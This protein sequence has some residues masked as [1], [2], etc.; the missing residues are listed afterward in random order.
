MSYKKIWTGQ[1]SLT[2]LDG[3]SLDLASSLLP[4]RSRIKP[5]IQIHLHLHAR[6][7]KKYADKPN[8][9]IVRKNTF[10]LNARLGLLESLK[11][12]VQ[13]FRWNPR[14]PGW[15]NYYEGDSYTPDALEDKVRLVKG[16]LQQA[17]PGSVWDLGAN[18]GLFSRLTSEMGA[19]TVAF[20]RDPSVVETCYLAAQRQGDTNLLPLVMD[21]ASPS[22]PIGWANQER[23][24]LAQRGPVDMVLALALALI[25]HLAI[26][27][28][29]PLKMIAE[30][31][32]SL[33]H[34][35]LVE[36][37]PRTDPKAMLLLDS[38][39]DPFESYTQERF[40]HEFSAVFHVE[41]K[42]LISGS[43]RYLY[44]L[45]NKR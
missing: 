28:N 3:L 45:R 44:L 1:L 27:N 12:T 19:S 15:S 9:G 35:A 17:H 14:E 31:F 38:R 23:M 40:E 29:V 36:F 39:Q 20:D 5:S 22:P 42:A 41:A 7:L 2:H 13:G 21:L 43:E 30:Y 25:H 18:T 6:L 37:I 16:F 11:S 33:A 24:G 26:G 8:S 32:G 10:K 4:L 34:W